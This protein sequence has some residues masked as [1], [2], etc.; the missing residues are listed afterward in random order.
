MYGFFYP[1]NPTD[2]TNFCYTIVLIV[3]MVICCVQLERER[4]TVVV[5]RFG[6]VPVTVTT[7]E[8]NTS[9]PGNCIQE[10]KP[11]AKISKYGPGYVRG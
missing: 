10:L 7:P 3:S 8:Q 4:E 9:L 2:L 11:S 6:T 5:N 1:R